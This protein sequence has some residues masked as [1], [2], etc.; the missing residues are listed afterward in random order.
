MVKSCVNLHLSSSFCHTRTIKRHALKNGKVSEKN[1]QK[2]E[3]TWKYVSAKTEKVSTALEALDHFQLDVPILGETGSGVS[4]LIDALTGQKN[5]IIGSADDRIPAMCPEYPDIRFWD[6]S[7]TE[8]IMDR[9]LEEQKKIL[10]HFDFYVIIVSN[11]QEACHTELA[12]TIGKLK[13]HY[14]FVQTKIDCH[15]QAQGGLCCSEAEILDGLRAQCAKELQQAKAGQSQLFL[16]NSLDT[17]TFDFFSLESVLKS[18]LDT[19]RTS[20]FAY[21]VAKIVRQKQEPRTCQIL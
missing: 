2:L 10:D 4:T 3:K 17:N 21:Y 6:A 16:I 20:A 11:W 13:K 5:G 8:N 14:H 7:G 12:R 19:I 9:P 1:L 18:D 15:L